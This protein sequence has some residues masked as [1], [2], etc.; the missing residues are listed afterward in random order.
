MCAMSK[1]AL[2]INLMLMKATPPFEQTLIT[3]NQGLFVCN[4]QEFC[5]VVFEKK[6]FKGLHSVCYVRII[7]GYYFANNVGGATL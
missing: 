2:A 7:F 4:I 5:S 3:H 6:I 1:L